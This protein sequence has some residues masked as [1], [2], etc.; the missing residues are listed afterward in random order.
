MTTTKLFAPVVALLLVVLSV[1]F[2]FFVVKSGLNPLL[3]GLT[4]LVCVPSAFAFVGRGRMVGVIGVLLFV[5]VG[6]LGYT[7]RLQ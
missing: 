6:I 7:I 2:S 1:A 5:A 4:I 3:H